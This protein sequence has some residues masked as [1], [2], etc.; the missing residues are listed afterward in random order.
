MVDFPAHTLDAVQSR[1]LAA[2]EAERLMGVRSTYIRMATGTGKCVDPDTLVWSDGLRRFGDLFDVASCILGPHGVADVV[3][4][5]DDGERDGYKVRLECGLE[6]DGT[7]AHRVWVRH[8][9]GCEGWLHVSDLGP[10]DHVAVARGRADWGS[11]V[12]PPDEAYALGLLIAD[13]CIMDSRTTSRLQIDKQLPVIRAVSPVLSRWIVMA[14]GRAT[15]GILVQEMSAN[16]AS[17]TVCAPNFRRMLSERYGIARWEYSHLRSVPPCILRGTRDVVR[18]FLRGYFDGDGYCCMVPEVSTASPQLARQ[19][20]QLLLGLGIYTRTKV[21]PTA[22]LPAHVISIRDVGVFEKEVGFTP[23]GLRKDLRFAKLSST[24]R[25]TNV[26]TVPCAG[27]LIQS[28]ARHI[29][30]KHKRRD[31][32]KNARN[33]FDGRKKPGYAMLA[34]FAAALPVD[35][36]ERVEMDRILDERRA[37]SAVES[38]EPSC[39]RR[40]DCEV[41]EQHAFVGNGII[42]HN[43]RVFSKFGQDVIGRGGRVLILNNTRDLVDQSAGKF[44]H[45]TGSPCL[46][47]MAGQRALGPARALDVKAVV[48]S[49]QSMQGRRLK[50]WPRDFFDAV[51]TDEC[52]FAV[53]PSFMSI[54]LHFA[55]A[56]HVGVTATDSRMDKKSLRTVYQ[57]RAFTYDLHEAVA[58]GNLIKPEFVKCGTSIDLRDIKIPRNADIPEEDIAAAIAPKLEVLANAIRKEMD[59]YLGVRQCLVFAPTVRCTMDLADALVGAGVSARGLHGESPDRK[60]TV[61]L[62]RE[63]GFRALVC[64]DLFTRGVDFPFLEAAF[65]LRITKSLA[66]LRQMI[67]RI[68]RLSHATGKERAYFV[69]PTWTG[70]D[71]DE[72]VNGVDAFAT[73]EVDHEALR[74]ARRL[75]EESGERDPQRALERG[76]EIALARWEKRQEEAFRLEQE[77]ERVREVAERRRRAKVHVRERDVQ[78]RRTVSDPVGQTAKFGLSVVEER[79]EFRAVPTPEQ[80]DRLVGFGFDRREVE[81]LSRSSCTRLVWREID[82]RKKGLATHKQVRLLTSRG[83]PE[84]EAM[85]LSVPEASKRIDQVLGPRRQAGLVF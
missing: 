42:N 54:P 68:T 74:I 8:E 63:G 9:D 32:W 16:H 35:C 12:I 24:P 85:A 80:V 44:E 79:E 50:E 5:Y 13:G 6:I 19:V 38:V 78:Y 2:I 29:R 57:T 49:V 37:W 28:A 73:D 11:V 36:P 77:A 4:W 48:A 15:N 25:N 64:R 82:R 46:V 7:P 60:A 52:D 34:E 30:M 58:D 33:Y 72:V 66:L 76:E 18:S 14:G 23:Y 71:Y 45:W 83:V 55:D 65:N 10:G 1:A 20:V 56:F 41:A 69:E 21:K 75:L 40:I 62:F 17:A 70:I 26:D 53:S 39:I 59:Q 81:G 3:G 61:D 27:A 43:T 67:G 22:K 51:V 84:R 47:E 31:A